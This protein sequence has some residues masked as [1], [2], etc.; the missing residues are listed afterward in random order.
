MRNLIFKI[1]RLAVFAIAILGFVGAANA[2]TVVSSALSVSTTVASSVTASCNTASVVIAPSATI[3]VSPAFT[4]TAAFN[5]S[6]PFQY[7][8]ATDLYFSTSTALT[9]SA[10][11]IPVSNFLISIDGGTA[12]PCNQTVPMILGN[13]VGGPAGSSCTAGDYIT[14]GNTPTKQWTSTHSY[15]ASI[16]FAGLGLSAGSASGTLNFSLYVN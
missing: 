5:V 13:T 11:N 8:T 9:G 6:N 16:N 1:G 4:C 7:Y 15:V 12:S 14:L 10:G 2:Q 3:G